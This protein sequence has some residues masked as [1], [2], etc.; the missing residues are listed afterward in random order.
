MENQFS[1]AELDRWTGGGA[2]GWREDNAVPA[3]W[4]VGGAGVMS[5]AGAVYPSLEEGLAEEGWVSDP[6]LPA[7][8][9]KLSTQ[10]GLTFLT[11]QH[12]LLG[13]SAKVL[14]HFLLTRAPQEVVIF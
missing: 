6:A 4:K 3:G 5:P 7:D 11:D 2:A 1:A 14:K 10:S 9:L 8:W 12:K 13:S